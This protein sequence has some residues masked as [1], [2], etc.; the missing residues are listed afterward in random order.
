[1]VR[2]RKEVRPAQAT[3]TITTTDP[4]HP[5][6]SN[7]EELFIYE[8]MVKPALQDKIVIVFIEGKSGSG[9]SSAMVMLELYAEMVFQKITGI[10]YKYDVV[11]QNVFTPQQ[12][13]KK[14]KW[15]VESP[16]LTFGVD[17]LRFLLPKNKWQSLIVQSISE[18]NETIRAVKSENMKKLTGIRYG[19]VIFYNSQSLTDVSKDVRKTVDMDILL[20]RAE[21]V[22]ARIYEFW[23][24]RYN[25][26]RPILRPR[27]LRIQI[28]RN[29]VL[30]PS[31]E[32]VFSRPPKIIFRKFL[33]A[34]VEAKAAIFRRKREKII[35]EIEKEYGHI[36]IEDEL[37]NDEIWHMVSR[38]AKYRKGRVVFSKEAK[39]I[40]RKMF[41]L[42]EY[43]F[44]NK[45]VPTFVKI[46]KERG[47]L[48]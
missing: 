18:I 2:G 7:F 5:L 48:E 30:I 40:I 26:E 34:S 27:R 35:K 24:E 46:A 44:R 1:M 10:K 21:H 23:T 19:G 42:S 31:T 41:D 17:E 29:M 14:L 15:W 20:H 33:K 3:I 9:K 47:L 8:T 4:N 38:M 45:F 39:L 37:R 11:Q 12:Y 25:I 28:A 16:A 22:R 6:L 13:Y 32:T 43:D 36:T